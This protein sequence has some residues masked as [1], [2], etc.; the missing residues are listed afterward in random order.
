MALAAFTSAAKTVSVAV[1]EGAS[2]SLTAAEIASLAEG[3]TLVKTGGGELT[4]ANELSVRLAA[5]D[6]QGGKVTLDDAFRREGLATMWSFDDAEDFGYDIAPAHAFPLTVDAASTEPP[7]LVEDGVSGRALH[8]GHASKTSGARLFRAD[9][10]SPSGHT[11]SGNSAFTFSFWMRPTKD[12][13]GTG[14]NFIHIDTMTNGSMNWGRGFF[15]G[16]V[17]KDPATGKSEW[18]PFKNLCFYCGCGWTRSGERNQN[19]DVVNA[20]KV[21]LATFD[22]DNY[23]FDGAWHQVVGTYENRVMRLYVDGRLM[24]ERTRSADL[25]VTSNPYVQIG[26]WSATDGGHKFAGDLD[27]LQ[28]LAG[29]WTP[30]QV[31]EEY[32]ACKPLRSAERRVT[33]SVEGAQLTVAEGASLVLAGSTDWHFSQVGGS[34][35]IVIGGSSSLSAD[36]YVDYSGVL[37]GAGTGVYAIDLSAET[38]PAPIRVPSGVAKIP[39]V[40]RIVFANAEGGIDPARPFVLAEAASFDLPD[41]FSGW[42]FEPKD[43]DRR[44]AFEVIDG[45]LVFRLEAPDFVSLDDTCTLQLCSGGIPVA[46]K[47]LPTG[48][49]S[50]DTYGPKLDQD[51]DSAHKTFTLASGTEY[52]ATGSVQIV[53]I[54]DSTVRASWRFAPL[55]D[56]PRID[57]LTV[58]LSLP[59][60]E[61]AGEEGH[62]V[63]NGTTY[64]FPATNAGETWQRSAKPVSSAEVYD[65]SGTML[66]AISNITMG[67]NGLLQ[68]NRT[69]NGTDFS[70]RFTTAVK[71]MTVGETCEFSMDISLPHGAAI[72]TSN[73]VVIRKSPEYA[74]MDKPFDYVLPGSALDFS[75]IRGTESPAGKYGRVLRVGDHF[76]FENL[77]GVPQRFYGANLC[78]KANIPN[79]DSVAR[80]AANFARIG[81]NAIRFHHQ[82]MPLCASDD[83]SKTSLDPEAID[84]FDALVAA[85]VTNGIYLTTDLYVSRLPTYRSLGIDR[86]G[87]V[88]M[89]EYK[90]LL[91]AHQ[92]AYE[93]L[94]AFL[95]TWFNHV[96]P[97]TGR[98][99]AEE[100]ALMSVALVN[101]GANYISPADTVLMPGW[102]QAWEDWLD[103]K[104]AAEPEV[105]GTITK[106]VPSTFQAKPNGPVFLRFVKEQED[107]LARRLK[108]FLRE[109]LN[110]PVPVTSMN[111]A[112][113]GSGFT[114]FFHQLTAA[115]NFDYRDQHRY[116]DH[117][118]FLA[119]KWSAPWTQSAT[120]P[121]TTD[122]AG[123]SD[124]F[125]RRLVGFPFASSE[126]NFCS[127]MDYRSIGGLMIGSMAALQDWDALWRFAWSHDASGVETPEKK[128]VSTFDISG[129]PIRL[130]QERT[131]VA[132]FLRRDLPAL[133]RTYAI[134]LDPAD[135]ANPTNG[136]LWKKY[137]TLTPAWFGWYA[138]IGTVV[139]NAWPAA[140]SMAADFDAAQQKD[141]AAVMA[142]LGLAYD[143]Q[144]RMPP[145]GDGRVRIDQRTGL[146]AV[147]AGRTVG[148]FAASGTVS[149]GP[150]S[151]DL[152]GVKATVCAMSLDDRDVASSRRILFTHL[153]DVQ[154]SGATYANAKRDTVLSVGKQPFL[155]R[156]AKAEVALALAGRKC[157]VY[158]LALDGSRRFEVPAQQDENGVLRFTAD[159]TADP[160]EVT[161]LYEIVQQVRG[162]FVLRYR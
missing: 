100:P 13:C 26:N 71:S 159:I 80:F 109:E 58:T 105:F 138:K 50:G 67:T 133:S 108:A 102:Q 8:F 38:P 82:E 33:E 117:P 128:G 97:Y 47:M 15:F 153:T 20:S 34:G 69:W 118:S 29:A 46:L 48:Y 64:A 103:G 135:Y 121:L 150:L 110:C 54:D 66:C 44:L 18:R 92:G 158:A 30:R 106:T 98:T 85:C 124:R 149:A 122:D 101:E 65:R 104:K 111:N 151:V 132:L 70:L 160:M 139:T 2:R 74:R 78:Q 156:T 95:R 62:G 53:Q 157:H 21:A 147:D 136:C 43:E 75:A 32:A 146:L 119:T 17:D 76:E 148:A 155:M 114:S 63:L 87:E 137:S 116:W 57:A 28:W 7:T 126:F 143:A 14:S 51:I 11:P 154:G 99:L 55:A 79:K 89:N 123:F 59:I 25:D 152:G 81:F 5:V 77:P 41:D 52:A 112:S 130:V 4:I 24:D 42:T 140:D 61:Y 90:R 1:E 125:Y 68:D 96:N 120:L 40:G 161:F 131:A 113:E 35:G 36:A 45:K 94:L 93:N 134:P 72:R 6:V 84:R 39:S 142:D 73:P 162:S 56:I 83:D 115:E 27:E 37:S 31:A 88:E 127:P 3:D 9:A 86:D 49:N 23:F 12:A 60:A 22:S 107:A 129:D 91:P 141:R 144:G 16:S 10:A 145:A 19:G